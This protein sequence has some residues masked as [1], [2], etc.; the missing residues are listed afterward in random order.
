MA[1]VFLLTYAL[2][3]CDIVGGGVEGVVT[4]T[5]GQD[6]SGIEIFLMDEND[7]LEDSTKTNSEGYYSITGVSSGEYNMLAVR[8][9]KFYY[10]NLINIKSGETE[11]IN[12][13][14][15]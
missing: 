14:I 13:T 15:P 4:S 8:N 9:Q 3:S 11:T 12:I 2:L 5:S 10:D 7:E 1:T 6:V